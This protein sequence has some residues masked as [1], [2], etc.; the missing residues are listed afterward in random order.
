[1]IV[2]NHYYIVYEIF[3]KRFSLNSIINYT[4]AAK[5][6]KF[7]HYYYYTTSLTYS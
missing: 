6:N 2:V 3:I 5:T 1:M 7:S 4:N